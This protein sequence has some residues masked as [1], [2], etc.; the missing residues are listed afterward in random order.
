LREEAELSRL[1]ALYTS[2]AAD[3]FEKEARAWV[4]AHPKHERKAEI[5]NLLSQPR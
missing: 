2:K 4:K 5:E 3:V 1:E